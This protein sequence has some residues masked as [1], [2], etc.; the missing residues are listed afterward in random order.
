MKPALSRRRP[1]SELSCGSLWSGAVVS[2]ILAVS[3]MSVAAPSPERSVQEE[4]VRIPGPIEALKL[5]L[6][7]ES[8]MSADAHPAVLFLHGSAVPFPA[9]LIF[10]RAVTP[11]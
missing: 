4:T 6:R 5:G 2:G 8:A 9:I 11:S 10:T 7:H 1:P 3:T